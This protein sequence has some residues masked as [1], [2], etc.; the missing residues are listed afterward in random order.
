MCVLLGFL[1]QLVVTLL[2]AI[3]GRSVVCSKMNLH[4]ECRFVVGALVGVCLA[5]T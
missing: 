4:M 3:G 1:P 5:W 2:E